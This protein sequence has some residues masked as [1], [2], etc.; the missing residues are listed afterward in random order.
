M[1]T[2]RFVILRH[3]VGHDFQRTSE[4]HCD[5]MFEYPTAGSVLLKT[6]TTACVDLNSL[7]IETPALAV[8]DHRIDYLEIQG[9]IGGNRGTVTQIASGRY[10]LLEDCSDRFAAEMVWRSAGQR[11]LLIERRRSV[12][13]DG[14]AAGSSW[15][16][17]SG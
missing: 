6:W 2:L 16:R 5:W 7:P 9:D 11:K 8:A 10:R 13:R 15:L 3:E 12:A 1:T 4:N 17:L 14:S